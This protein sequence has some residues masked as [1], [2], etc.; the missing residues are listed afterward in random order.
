MKNILILI[1]HA[2]CDVTARGHEYFPVH[3]THPVNGQGGA[4]N[5]EKLDPEICYFTREWGDNV[6]DWNS[7]NS[8]SRVNR[9]WGEMPMLKQA[10]GYA[11]TDYQYTCYDVLYRNTRQHAG[12][13]LWHSFDHQ[14]GYIPILSTEGLWMLSVSPS[15]R[16][17]CSVHSVRPVRIRN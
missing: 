11:K 6:D 16:I 17:I 5:T 13:C 3:F 9:S 7:H 1:V 15:Y 4:F 2:G 12:G 14:R 10:Q 8:P